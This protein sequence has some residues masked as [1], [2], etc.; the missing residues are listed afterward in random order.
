[1]RRIGLLAL[2][3]LFLGL[4]ARADAQ[5]SQPSAVELAK[6]V[7]GFYEKTKD[8][9]AHFDQTYRYMAMARTQKS[10]G[11]VQ[12]KK[13]GFMRW[14]YEKPYVKQFVL[15][16]KTF[17]AY[18][19]DDNAVMVN[20]KFSSDSLS[21][22]VSFLWGKGKLVEEFNLK[23]VER[24]DYGP[25]VLELTPKKPQAGFTKLF[26]V[27]D[28][29]TGMVT[30]SVIFDTEGNE[31]RIAFSDPKTNQNI[32]DDRFSFQIPKGASVKEL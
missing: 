9:T 10:S 30:T 21:A 28:P 32:P 6:K 23:K 7:Q 13:P 16:G 17:Y 25:V 19:P 2:M 27:V 12:V 20:R 22:A 11:I 18:E 3:T 5:Q 8:F 1:M 31:N 24:P 29:Q 4:A 26:F 14:D 15:D